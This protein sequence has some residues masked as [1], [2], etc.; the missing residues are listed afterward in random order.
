MSKN[1]IFIIGSGRS[2]TTV[3]YDTL[4]LH[5]DVCWFSNV[6]DK[7]P[8]T[9]WL[10]TLNRI[11]DA[12]LIGNIMKQ[13]ITKRKT[14][15]L[16]PSEG[17]NIY[18]DYCGFDNKRRLTEVDLTDE[19][20]HKFMQVV[21][22]HLHFTG[23]PRFLSKQ[24]ANSQRIRAIHA[25]FPNAYY[26]HLIRDGRAVTSSLHKV[27]WWENTDIWWLNGKPNKWQEMGEDPIELCALQWQH[28]VA[29]ILENKH[30]FGGR[31]LE[32][33]YEDLVADAHTV[34]GKI[35]RF[36]E[37]RE[38]AEFSQRIPNDLTDMNYK[39][40]KNL[41]SQQK[42]IVHKSIGDFLVQL[43]YLGQGEGAS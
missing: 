19:M 27:P 7:Y 33:R 20:Q 26:V 10:P 41:S 9:S 6:T 18:H 34:M 4:A 35:L 32:I 24:T 11:I 28:D 3:L 12:P 23:K 21:D 16:R 1:P 42:E 43:G 29:E 31:Y 13:R 15:S 2:G 17:G 40:D 25:M 38:T 30:L 5:P 37:L 39:W 14:P 36:C 8:K 22:N